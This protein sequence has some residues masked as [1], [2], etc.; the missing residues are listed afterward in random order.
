MD[1]VNLET[2]R[3]MWRREVEAATTYRHLADRET[4]AQRKNILL[5]L[6]E[7]EDNHAT[8]WAEGV[9]RHPHPTMPSG[10]TDFLMFRPTSRT[11]P[12]TTI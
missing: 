6:A 11:R 2:V 3:K 9:S 12:D 1:P 8:R 10:L 5:R 4:D 7:Q